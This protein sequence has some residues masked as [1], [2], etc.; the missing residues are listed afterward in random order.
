MA[1]VYKVSAEIGRSWFIER[2]LLGEPTHAPIVNITLETSLPPP[3]PVPPRLVL[4]LPEEAPRYHHIGPLSRA[5][6]RTVLARLRSA[7][8]PTWARP[9]IIGA[10]SGEQIELYIDN[11]EE[12]AMAWLALHQL[13]AQLRT[14]PAH[15]VWL[16]GNA[17]NK[18]SE[19]SE[20]PVRRRTLTGTTAANRADRLNAEESNG[21]A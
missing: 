19:G 1:T 7:D 12:H 8:I 13:G 11:R 2:R 15:H 9:R 6:T 5:Q 4:L 14:L 20:E 3:P 21:Q 17:I 10:L 18:W 16:T